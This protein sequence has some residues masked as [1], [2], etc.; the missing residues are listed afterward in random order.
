MVVFIDRYS[1]L[2]MGQNVLVPVDRSPHSE[3]A[4]EYVLEE[5]SDP[6]IILL[7]VINPVSVFGHASGDGN[8]DIE[9]YRQSQQRQREHAEQI[10]KEYQ[11]KG[12]ERGLEVKTNIQIGKPARR[13][14]E[15]AKEH[16]V[17]HIILGSHGRSG[18]G[19]VLLG[20]VAETVTRR[21]PVPVTIIR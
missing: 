15:T 9:E 1:L 6:T 10:L 18:V 4:F 7:H 8:F 13:I 12:R 5:I 11:E 21:S 16:D 3:K 19:R 20:S 14:L 2:D 17:D